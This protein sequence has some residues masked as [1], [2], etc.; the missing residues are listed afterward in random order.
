ML[1]ERQKQQYGSVRKKAYN[2]FQTSVNLDGWT[3]N[4]IKYRTQW[5]F[6]VKSANFQ[7]SYR[8]AFF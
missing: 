1:L 7:L 6:S 2:I 8:A 4:F 5:W 3:S